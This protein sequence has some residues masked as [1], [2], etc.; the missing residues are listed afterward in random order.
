MTE[1]ILVSPNT[2]KGAITLNEA[3]LRCFGGADAVPLILSPFSRPADYMDKI[4]GI[5]LTGGGDLGEKLLGEPLSPYA[6]DIDERRDCLEAELIR[7]GTENKIPVL[8]ICRGAQVLNSALGGGLI[9]H[10]N[11]H[12]QTQERHIPSHEI[13]ISP[14]SLLYGIIKQ[15]SARV[16]SFHHQCI[17]R[18]APCLR[19]SA[20][21]HDGVAEAVEW[22]EPR[23]FCLGVQWHPEALTGA[24]G[25]N[26]IKSF[27]AACRLYNRLNM[28]PDS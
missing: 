1:F 22:C 13:K 23:Y 10:I 25:D 9:Q 20:I 24:A 14:S 19:I 12:R 18:P 4:S 27:L 5:M 6:E 28:S 16:N 7:L 17:S 2:I 3:Y 26:I 21:S 15:P 11:G 8:G